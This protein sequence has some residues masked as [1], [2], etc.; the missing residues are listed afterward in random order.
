MRNIGLILILL[1]LSPAWAG[2]Q[3]SQETQKEPSLAELARRERARR[4]SL[5][6]V[7]VITNA[8]LRNVR[9]LISTST[10]PPSA[11]TGEESAEG[12]AGTDAEAEAEDADQVTAE[13]KG[14]IGDARR[15]VEQAVNNSNVLQLKMNDLRNDYFRAD[16]GTT[17]TRIQQQLQETIQEIELSRQEVQAARDALQ[18]IQSQARQAGLQPGDIRDAVGEL[19]EPQSISTTP[20]Q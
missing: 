4:A 2:A 20:D 9:G 19:P 7:P 8:T 14:R 10:A 17:Q 3:E 12:Q 5:K 16:D 6:K 15:K 1:L 18:S 11:S 13:W